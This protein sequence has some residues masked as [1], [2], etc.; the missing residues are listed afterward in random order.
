MHWLP[1]NVPSTTLLYE[2]N[3]QWDPGDWAKCTLSCCLF[4]VTKTGKHRSQHIGSHLI[5]VSHFMRH[6]GGQQRPSHQ[7]VLQV[8]LTQIHNHPHG[9]G[10]K[11]ARGHASRIPRLNMVNAGQFSRLRGVTEYLKLYS[12]PHKR[13]IRTVQGMNNVMMPVSKVNHFSK[14]A[15]FVP[16]TLWS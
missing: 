14:R 5:R 16:W 10:S 7:M 13:S 6:T 8:E 1:L 3:D 9:A 11:R 2:G 4:G 12:Q 15:S